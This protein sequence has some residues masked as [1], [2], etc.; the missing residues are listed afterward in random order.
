MEGAGVS[1]AAGIQTFRGSEG[2]F[3]KPLK[4]GSVLELFQKDTFGVKATIGIVIHMLTTGKD[5][6]KAAAHASQVSSLAEIAAQAQPT[7]FHKLLGALQ[8][9]GILGRV[10]TQNIDDLEIKTGL[11]TGGNNP[12]CVQLHGSAMEVICT[13]CSFTE[14]V[15]HHFITLKSGELPSCPQCES[16]IEERRIQEKRSLG[17]GGF[18]RPSIILYGESHPKGEDI[19]ELQ[20]IDEK[21]ADCLLVVGTSLKTFGAVDLIKKLSANLQRNKRGQVYYMDLENP[22]LGLFNVFDHIVRADCQTFASH[23]LE[24]LKKAPSTP[25]TLFKGE[26]DLKDWV[27]EGNVRNDFRPSWAWV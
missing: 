8:S 1:Q 27:N 14:N 18:L 11:T 15:Y 23:M 3:T 12:N 21:R 25:L 22:P 9:A 7:A 4:G 20:I 2:L 13:H 10:Y 26:D 24:E 17:Q 6:R 16:R 19:Y 5:P